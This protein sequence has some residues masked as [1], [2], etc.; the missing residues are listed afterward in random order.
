MYFQLGELQF[1]NLLGLGSFNQTVGG[2][3]PD[4]PRIGNK[5]DIQFTGEELERISFNI[6]LHREFIEPQPFI[7]QIRGYLSDG[8][9]V[10]FVDGNGKVYGNFVVVSIGE[11][12]QILDVDGTKI[13][14]SLSVELKEF[15]NDDIEA[16]EAIEL[17][18]AAG[19]LEENTPPEIRTISAS[20]TPLAETLNV[21]AVAKT[22]SIDSIELKELAVN[23][24]DQSGS[25]MSR[26]KVKMTTA[27]DSLT[28]ALETVEKEKFKFDSASANFFQDLTN[29]QRSATELKDAAESQDLTALANASETLGQRMAAVD[30][31][32]A[33]LNVLAII[34]KGL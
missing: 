26:I 10:P 2:R 33:P 27:V 24:P 6:P 4:S 9:A 11:T 12:S 25:L 30:V 3:F 8:V 22:N 1:S 20:P 5:S 13:A 21:V 15:V 7:D 18:S 16:T 29:F 17:R 19:A 28:K 14:V 34:R 23:V 31:S 32:I